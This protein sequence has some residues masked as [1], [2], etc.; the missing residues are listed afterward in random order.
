MPKLPPASTS[1]PEKVEVA[2]PVLRIDPPVIVKP[3]EESKPPPAT[4]S[5]EENV[6]VAEPWTISEDV[7]MSPERVVVPA[8]KAPPCTE[9]S[10]EGEVVPMPTEPTKVE[11]VVEVAVK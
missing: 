6:E 7:A 2:V 1:P 3:V 11:A 9:K 4:E 10:W 8:I 5:P